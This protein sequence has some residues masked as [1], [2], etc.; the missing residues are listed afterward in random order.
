MKLAPL[1]IIPLL[2]LFSLGGKKPDHNARHT[3]TP[4]PR[5]TATPTA[6]PTEITGTFSN[7]NGHCILVSSQA[8]VWIHDAI[9]GPC[10]GSGIK[11]L[12][13]TDVS[14]ENVQILHAKVSISIV[15]SDHVS[16]RGGRL[17]DPQGPKPEGQQIIA[18]GSSFVTIDGVY[19]EFTGGGF[20]E[21]AINF[22]RSTDSIIKNSTIV[23]G[24]SP[25][26]CGI[27]LDDGAQRITV[28]NN[29]ISWQ[30]NCGIGVA[31]GVGHYVDHND[32]RYTGQNYYAWNQYAGPCS[33]TFVNNTGDDIPGFWNGGGCTVMG[34]W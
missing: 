29:H 17:I 10:D 19:T 4:T 14:I 5:A 20:Q 12:N 8:H 30:T 9:I 24:G 6:G 15:T 33:V 22:Y 2:V 1:L 23:G 13:S 26:G 11:V 18:N 34:Q 31:N 27:V 28:A 16:V 3:P 32:V 21:D 25:T 7:P